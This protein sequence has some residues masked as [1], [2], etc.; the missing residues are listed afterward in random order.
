M[1]N[2]TLEA[3]L[4]SITNV[5]E[6]VIVIIRWERLGQFRKMMGARRLPAFEIHKGSKMGKMINS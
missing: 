1:L 2:F 4:P 6:F 5:H 3:G